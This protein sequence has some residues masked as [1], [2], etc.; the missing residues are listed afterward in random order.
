MTALPPSEA[1]GLHS[2]C[3]DPSPAVAARSIGA[4]GTV[5]AAP[6]GVADASFDATLW[7]TSL[8]AF[9]VKKYSV[10][11]VNPVTGNVVVSGGKRRRVQGR[12][13]LPL[14]AVPSYTL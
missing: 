3:A 14:A 4:S 13:G 10:P 9:T 2:R 11:L 6:F 8:T 7:P 5:P 12:V 1:G